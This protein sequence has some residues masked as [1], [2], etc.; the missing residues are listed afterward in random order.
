[1]DN[2]IKRNIMGG[3]LF[4]LSAFFFSGCYTQL[5]KPRIATETKDEEYYVEEPQDYE[6]DYEEEDYEEY[7]NDIYL[8]RR[9]YHDVHYYGFYEPP[10]WYDPFFDPYFYRPFRR[11]AA[12]FI[13]FYD[14]C[15]WCP[16]YFY[17]YDP[18]YFYDFAYWGGFYWQP[19]RFTFYYNDGRPSVP[20]KRRGFGRG[21]TRVTDNFGKLPKQ[22]EGRN[23]SRIKKTVAV[24]NK[25][26]TTKKVTS[27]GV[28]NRR[29]K[30]SAHPS[31]ADNEIQKS[32][33]TII[34]NSGRTKTIKNTD[35]QNKSKNRGKKL[36][37]RVRKS[38]KKHKSSPS[39]KH[40]SKTRFTKPAIL[41][42]GSA[43]SP[44]KHRSS[45][46]KSISRKSF[47]GGSKSGISKGSSPNK[48]SKGFKTSSR[49]RKR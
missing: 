44:K 20:V 27:N 35:S 13:G 37:K 7:Y 28:S 34:N 33:A 40:I 16:T 25:K 30:K 39:K 32:D 29:I 43:R 14:P 23:S 2:L 45:G 48:V 38:T 49:S 47:S 8:T 6:E 9:Y 17:W 22:I 10:W 19:Y 12:F 1:M 46:R 42:K 36:N 5:A 11:H 3:F 31:I 15:I 41:K 4:I 18:Y 24:M 26:R 21:G